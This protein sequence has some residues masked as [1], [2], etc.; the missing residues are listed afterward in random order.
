VELSLLFGAT[1]R[2]ATIT[3]AGD[4]AQRLD[5]DSGFESWES[6][7]EDLG[8]D[9]LTLSP[10]KISYRST[11][12]IMELSQAVLGALV[13]AKVEY[14]PTRS[15]APVELIRSSHDG[16]VV[17]ILGEA[18]RELAAREPLASVAVIARHSERARVYYEGL[19][20]S[21]VPRLRL[22]TEQ[23][24]SFRPGVE[25]TD[26]HQVKG[27]EFDY[28]VMVDVDAASYPMTDAARHLLHIGTTRAAH[29]L[30]LVT[31]QA[32]SP[33]LPEWLVEPE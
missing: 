26:V 31:T 29:Q 10:L 32:P 6:L 11:A 16:E 1:S 9:P 8:L 2:R 21:E 18:L 33:L 13:D 22:V 19:L 14:H 25:V 23:D 12:E 7:Y 5:L 24:F 17:A 27:L 3:L 15:G 28:V 30:W 4:A 20:R